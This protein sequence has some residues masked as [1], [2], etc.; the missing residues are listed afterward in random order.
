MEK[1]I[2]FIILIGLLI[3]VIGVLGYLFVSYVKENVVLFRGF[4]WKIFGEVLL[5]RLYVTVRLVIFFMAGIFIVGWSIMKMVQTSGTDWRKTKATLSRV[6]LS[7]RTINSEPEEFLTTVYEFQVQGNKYEVYDEVARYS[8]MP[9]EN[10]IEEVWSSYKTKDVFYNEDNPYQT[11][12]I[13]EDTGIVM[14]I[15]LLVTGFLFML[16]SYWLVMEAY[17]Q[18]LS[19]S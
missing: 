12:L 7:E 17:K 4:N 16:F 9:V 14:Y 13:K 5:W 10:Q 3:F 18:K 6:T 8:F 19:D 11:T 1:T 15:S 2:T